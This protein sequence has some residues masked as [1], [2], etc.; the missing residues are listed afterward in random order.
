M[1]PCTSRSR[2][3]FKR[4]AFDGHAKTATQVDEDL[5]EDRWDC[6]NNR[7]H[8]WTKNSLVIHSN[9]AN[10]KTLHTDQLNVLKSAGAKTKK[11]KVS[12]NF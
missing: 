5:Q 1:T 12:S 2:G 8:A 11:F 7:L 10:D 4:A 9:A 3:V 6:L